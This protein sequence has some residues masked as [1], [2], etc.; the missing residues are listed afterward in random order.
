M[1]SS[2]SIRRVVRRTFAT[3]ADQARTLLPLAAVAVVI[4]RALNGGPT[5]S[6]PVLALGVF[7]LWLFVVALF[8][9]IVVMLAANTLEDR[10]S[11]G[12]HRLISTVWPMVVEL[13]LVALVALVAIM[14]FYYLASL[15]ALV[16]AISAIAGGVGAHIGVGLVVIAV[17]GVMLGLAPGMY[18]LTVWSLAL[19]VVVLERPGGLRALRRS[20]ELVYGNRLRVLVLVVLFCLLAGIGVRGLDF[21]G[22]STGPSHGLA[23]LLAGMLLAPIPLLGATVLYLELRQPPTVDAPGIDTTPDILASSP[24]ASNTPGG[25]QPMDPDALQS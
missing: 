24:A 21:V 8:T 11:P 5:K 1:T 18:L 16:L 10:P 19:P 13:V 12:I 22:G 7:A 23:S 20:R 4:V 3:Y 15:V 9:G 6:A 2:I 17:L 14:F 25:I